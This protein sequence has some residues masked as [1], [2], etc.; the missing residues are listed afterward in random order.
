VPM[1]LS[2][3][4]VHREQTGGVSRYFGVDNAEALAD[5]LCNI[6]QASEPFVVRDLRPDVDERVGAFATE[7]TGVIRSAMHSPRL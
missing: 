1:I 3:I 5:H 2:D 7:F 4:D 6:F